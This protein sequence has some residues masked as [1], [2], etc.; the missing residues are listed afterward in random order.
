[1]GQTIKGHWANFPIFGM[2]VFLVFCLIFEPFIKLPLLVGWLGH[3]HP[4]VLH[5]P[6]VLLLLVSIMGLLGKKVSTLLLTITTIS[7]LM[8]AITGFFLGTQALPKGNLLLW[9]QWFGAA[10]A[11]LAVIWYWL[12]Q[13]RLDKRPYASIIQVVLIVLVGITGHYGGM[14][15]HGVDFLALPLGRDPNKIP[16]NPLVYGHVVM[17]ILENKCV[18]CHN[19][20][21]RKGEFMMTGLDQLLKG[22]ETGPAIVAN[23]PEKSL[24]LQRIHLPM[25]D[26]EHMP[27]EG[28][29]PLTEEEIAILE[30]WIALG[31]SDSLRLTHLK[32]DEPLSVLIKKQ[33]MPEDGNAYKTFPKIADSVLLRLNTDY[34][35]LQRISANSNAL[36]AAAFL[37]PQYDPHILHGIKEVALNLV[38]LDL[39]GLP[40]GD[41]EM[42]M[43]ALCTNLERLELDRTPVDDAWFKGLQGLTKLRLLKAYSTGLADASVG[44]LQGME[45]LQQLYVWDT[46]ISEAAL[47]ELQK[48]LPGL[49][50]NTGMGPETEGA[51]IETIKTAVSKE[52]KK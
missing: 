23:V 17:P 45:G 28:K 41:Q 38:S 44:V 11:L 39:S 6:I 16:E 36:S 4:L 30:R 48:Q 49:Y 19:P 20:D 50:I 24:L 34:L 29:E 46:Q 47:T 14:V 5:F 22:G 37:P 12:R 35:T 8:T 43:V 52:E 42:E 33:L 27:P 1:M 40:L 32:A 51:F 10:V 9:H 25:D 7:A 31:A 18:S 21:K 26:E 2:T 13:N 15:T 3:W